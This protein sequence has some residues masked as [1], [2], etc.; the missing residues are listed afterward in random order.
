MLLDLLLFFFFLE[1]FGLQFL[2]SFVCA[3]FDNSYFLLSLFELNGHLCF[4][5]ILF[6]IFLSFSKCPYV[7]FSILFYTVLYFLVYIFKVL[8][9][10]RTVKVLL[11][12][13]MRVGIPRI[14]L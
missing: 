3:L 2:V 4:V 10:A 12:W 6:L 7:L 13:F 8:Q 14:Y 5:S 9:K 11:V 1:I